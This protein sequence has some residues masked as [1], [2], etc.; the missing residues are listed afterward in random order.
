MTEQDD[1]TPAPTPEDEAVP[2]QKDADGSPPPDE[3]DG[4]E[5]V[6]PESPSGDDETS[7][8]KTQQGKDEPPSGDEEPE[9]YKNFLK[10]FGGDKEKAAEHYWATQRQNASMARKLQER[11]ETPRETPETRAP[12]EPEYDGQAHLA[13]IDEQLKER[14]EFLKNAPTQDQAYLAALDK[15]DKDAEHY[16]RRLAEID[17]DLKDA[18]E[19]ERE[20]LAK[21]RADAATRAFQSATQRDQLATQ[22][23]Q[24]RQFG[25]QAVKDV[26]MLTTERARVIRGIKDEERNQKRERETAAAERAQYQEEVRGEFRSVFSETF[27]KLGINDKTPEGKKLLDKAWPVIRGQITND[28][29]AASQPDAK[30][31]V[32]IEKRVPALIRGFMELTGRS[33]QPTGTRSPAVATPSPSPSGEARPAGQRKL[34]PQEELDIARAEISRKWRTG[35]R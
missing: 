18:D 9:S 24:F 6:E 2:E 14:S 27:E 3:D 34:S 5:L 16:T 7:P 12:E 19:F 26:K 1:P 17:E 32:N 25:E 20:K 23:R 29:W 22:W 28:L 13:V 30:F 11:D 31:R 15:A 35:G 4:I 33:V 21:R 10:K 8:Q